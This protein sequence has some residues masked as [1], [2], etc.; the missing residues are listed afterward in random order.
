MGSLCLYSARVPVILSVLLRIR[1]VFR[2]EFKKT[3]K[4]TI[5]K[6]SDTV[7]YLRLF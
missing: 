7:L 6:H 5:K 3:A 2:I 4:W 1:L